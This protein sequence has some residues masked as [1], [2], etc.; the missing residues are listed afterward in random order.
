MTD[1]ISKCRR[2]YRIS[3]FTDHNRYAISEVVT[4]LVAID[5]P[6]QAAKK[7][8][9][10]PFASEEAIPA[11]LEINARYVADVANGWKRS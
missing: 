10:K 6:I 2:V 9:I 3:T 7:L 4:A 1:L 5:N 11:G 8:S